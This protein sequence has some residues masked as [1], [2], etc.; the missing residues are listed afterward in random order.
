[1][2]KIS[3]YVYIAIIF[4]IGCVLLLVDGPPAD[5]LTD[6]IG[7]V[8]TGGLLGGFALYQFGGMLINFIKERKNKKGL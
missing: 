7:I 5:C 4:I 1:M 2:G 3:L 8:L 6:Y